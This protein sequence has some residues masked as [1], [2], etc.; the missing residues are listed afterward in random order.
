MVTKERIIAAAAV[1]LA[2]PSSPLGY[3]L[4]FGDFSQR[5][6]HQPAWLIALRREGYTQFAEAGFPTTHDEDWRFTNVSA[7]A[8]T[9]FSLLP[10]VQPV[11]EG[12]LERFATSRFACRLVFVNGRYAPEL[13]RVPSLPKGVKVGSLADEIA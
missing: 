2:K 7:I 13:S 10:P 1:G 11:R 6:S 4:E 9:S 3:S 8:Q 12:D 5:L